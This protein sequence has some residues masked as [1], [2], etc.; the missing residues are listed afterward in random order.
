[1]NFFIP[2]LKKK[3]FF[4]IISIHQITYTQQ[5]VSLEKAVQSAISLN[6]T[7]LLAI[8]KKEAEKKLTGSMVNIPNLDLIFEAPTGN[9]MRPGLMQF[10]EFPTVYINQYKCQ[11]IQIAVSDAEVKLSQAMLKFYTKQS[12]ILSQYYQEKTKLFQQYDTIFSKLVT[13]NRIRFEVGQVSVLEK[14]NSE[15]KYKNI[16]NLLKQ[17]EFERKNG[18]KQ[19]N[20]IC[21][22]DQKLSDS[23][24]LDK[25]EELNLDYMSNLQHDTLNLSQNPILNVNDLKLKYNLKLYSIE[26]N[27]MLPGLFFGYLNQGLPNTTFEYRIRFGISIPLWFW[28]NISNIKYAQHKIKVQELENKVKIHQLKNQFNQAYAEYLYNKEVLSYYKTIGLELANEI[29]RT[30]T[31]SFKQGTINYFA[32]LMSLDQAFQIQLNYLDSLK[33]YNLSIIQLEFIQGL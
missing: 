10:V 6:P 33:N 5:Y 32:Y 11:K 18:I 4:F 24:V 25:F 3:L 28:K 15:A 2:A 16:R 29:I 27:K 8:Q 30:A 7:A 20:T 12:Y 9:E 22:P 21:F 1:L 17:A 23:I 13:T 14:I 26:K 31:E 19:L